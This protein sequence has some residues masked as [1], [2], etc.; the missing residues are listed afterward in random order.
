AIG[1]FVLVRAAGLGRSVWK[2]L[3]QHVPTG[4]DAAAVRTDLA[5]LPGVAGVHDLHLWTLTSGMDVATVHLVA[6]DDEDPHRLL[7]AA[8][9]LLRERHQLEHATVQI[10]SCDRI[11]CAELRW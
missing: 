9:G 2:V 1:C 7:H 4:V 6:A 10:E 11:G 5:G 3:G 8:S